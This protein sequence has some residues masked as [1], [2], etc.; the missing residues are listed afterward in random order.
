MIKGYL[1]ASVSN[2]FY[3]KSIYSQIFNSGLYNNFLFDFLNSSG[4]AVH[5]LK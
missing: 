4:N 2:L 1:H 5:L 3:P